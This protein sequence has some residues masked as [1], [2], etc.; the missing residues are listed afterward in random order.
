MKVVQEERDVRYRLN[1]ARAKVLGDAMRSAAISM[2]DEP[3][4]GNPFVENTERLSVNFRM[5]DNLNINLMHL[6]LSEHTVKS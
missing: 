5:P 1:A 6:Y 4:D 2:D 3:K